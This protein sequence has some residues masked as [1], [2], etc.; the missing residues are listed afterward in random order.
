MRNCRYWL[1]SWLLNGPREDGLV[2]KCNEAFDWRREGMLSDRSLLYI[3]VQIF[4]FLYDFWSTKIEF[5]IH[6]PIEL[7]SFA[8]DNPAF[9]EN[10]WSFKASSRRKQVPSDFE[11]WNENI[12]DR[13]FTFAKLKITRAR[14]ANITESSEI[15]ERE[16]NRR[17]D[18]CGSV[19]MEWL[20]TR[21][22]Q[23]QRW[24]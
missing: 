8:N 18:G 24:W 7:K 6:R 2:K 22:Y 15:F 17:R 9:I 1:S 13:I 12:P 5:Q 23:C 3:L 19:G 21:F 10:R 14:N 16:R 4:R 11:S 20:T